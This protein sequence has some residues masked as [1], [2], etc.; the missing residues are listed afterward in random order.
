MAVGIAAATLTLTVVGCAGSA[1]SV[2]PRE[3]AEPVAAPRAEPADR[4]PG[5]Q[6]VGTPEEVGV[7]H[8]VQAR[9]TLWRIA[10]AYGMSVHEL[11]SRNGIEDPDV[12]TE[13]NRLFI[14]GA[15][16]VVDVPAYSPT[17][18]DAPSVAEG[19]TWPVPGGRSFPDS[20]RRD[21]RIGTRA[22]T[23]V[24]VRVS[25]SWPSAR[26]AWSTATRECEA[27]ARP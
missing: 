14:P 26:A 27:T 11:A 6:P 22:W 7:Y 25:R 18:L 4:L 16:S 10:A 9:Q 12:L 17:A 13:G 15:T 5:K 24:G 21:A 23:S 19:W 2:T 8:T 3:R 20:V 1:R